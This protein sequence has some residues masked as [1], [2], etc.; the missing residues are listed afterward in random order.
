MG[1]VKF[2]NGSKKK[3]QG[4]VRAIDYIVDENKTEIFTFKNS[5]ENDR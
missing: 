1:I 3:I 2:I 5:D 4:L